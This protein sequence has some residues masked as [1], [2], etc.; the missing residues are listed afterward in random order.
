LS[1]SHNKLPPELHIVRGTK[2]ENQGV[3]IPE[4]IKKRIPKAYWLADPS[5]WDEDRFIEETAEYLFKVYGIG[6]DQDQ[7]TL[8]FLAQQ[9][10]IY[11]KCLKGFN[12]SNGAVITEYNNGKTIG[13][14]PFVTQMDK[15]LTK[16]IS[17]MNELGLTPRG[18]LSGNATD[19]AELG[20]LIGG[21]ENFK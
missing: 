20:D 16:I 21:P 18:R 3:A 11:V 15:T 2:G 7:H 9:I 1:A 12:Q 13:P 4:S 19:S 8:S 10:S 5:S 17:L 14:S 6:S